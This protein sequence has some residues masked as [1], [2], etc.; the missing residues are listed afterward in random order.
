MSDLKLK[1][2]ISIFR[3][4]CSNNFNRNKKEGSKLQYTLTILPCF[5]TPYSLVPVNLIFNSI[6]QFI[7]N[8]NVTLKEAAIIMNCSSSLSFKLYYLRFQKYIK[9]WVMIIIQLLISIEG[10]C[11]QE[12]IK[13]ININNNTKQNWDSFKKYLNAYFNQLSKLPK[14]TMIIEELKYPYIHNHF[15]HIKMGLGP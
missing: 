5:L 1:T 13:E 15:C 7:I 6:Q 9:D 4:I 14:S 8:P 10:A 11:K 2:K 3:I 12:Q